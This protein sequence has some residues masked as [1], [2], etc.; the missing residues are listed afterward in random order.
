MDVSN[1]TLGYTCSTR[2]LACDSI[3][4]GVCISCNRSSI[5]KVLYDGQCIET[6]PPGS[7]ERDGICIECVNDCEYCSKNRWC[8][9]CNTD[10]FLVKGLCYDNC[11]EGLIQSGS[12][13]T[14]L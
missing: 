10:F 2:C 11:P 9:K 1:I 14:T 7:E 12:S 8:D 6:C 13:C 5:F 3:D 4:L